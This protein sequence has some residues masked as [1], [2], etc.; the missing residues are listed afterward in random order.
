MPSHYI[1]LTVDKYPK[2][3]L[4]EGVRSVAAGMPM[5]KAAR[6]HCVPYATLHAHVNGLY[7]SEKRGRRTVLLEEEEEMIVSALEYCGDNGWPCDRTDMRM[8][9]NDYCKAADINVPWR[10][11]GPGKDFLQV[12]H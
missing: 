2:I 7:V 6:H 4:Q 3:A 8:M 11:D 10:E 12:E 5:R 1:R 9:V